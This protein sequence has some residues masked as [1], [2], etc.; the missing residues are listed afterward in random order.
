MELLWYYYDNIK[1]SLRYYYGAIMGLL[2]YHQCTIKVLLRISGA[3]WGIP[4]C[5]QGILES[6]YASPVGLALVSSWQSP[7]RACHVIGE[8]AQWGQMS[9]ARLYR[10]VAGI[11]G[12]V[13]GGGLMIGMATEV[14]RS[15]PVI[16]C[17]DLFHPHDD[18]DDHFDLATLYA[19]PELD[20]KGVVLDQGRKQLERPGR[21]PVSQMNKITG[22][23]VPTVIGLADLLKCPDDQA[24]DQPAQFQGAVELIVRTLRA[25]ARPVCIATAGSV[26]DVVCAFNREPGLFRTNVAMVLAFI[27]EASEVKFQEYNVGLDPQ[28]FVGLMRSG[29]PVYWVPCFDGGL[30]QNRGHASFWR[31]SQRA[32]LE[33]AAPEVIQYFIYALEKETA[34]PLGFLSRDVE[35][36]RRARLFAGTR[37]LWCAAVLGVMSGRKV[38]FEGGR[39]LC[40]APL[41]SPAASVAGR[42]PL[43]G[44]S[45]AEIS[46]NDTGVV[47]CGVGPGSHKVKRF[48]VRDSASYEQGMTEATAALLSSLGRQGEGGKR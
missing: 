41:S 12:A 25:S 28:A 40:V 1:V 46:V 38:V 27:G 35:P 2:W 48:E 3:A 32:L 15:V 26:R 30:W 14:G 17:T 7:A 6:F 16:Y 10:L 43:F 22:R 33:K 34:E 29:L 5:C 13:C 4:A 47:S 42:K 36:E 24:L 20:L 23:N 18:P 44:F 9:A 11:V 8:L 31:A 21:I 19:M 45:E 39:W 37:N